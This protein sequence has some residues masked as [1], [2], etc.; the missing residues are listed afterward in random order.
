MEPIVIL[1]FGSQLSQLIARRIRE[2]GVYCELLPFDTP[3]ATI[4]RLSPRGFILSGGPN[5]V[6]DLESPDLPDYLLH[7]PL[8]KLGICYGMQLLARH[9]GGKVQQTGNQEYGL[10]KLHVI[11][12]SQLFK[13]LPSSFDVW[14]SHG[15]SITAVPSGFNVLAKSET[16]PIAAMEE[17]VTKVYGVLFHPEVSHTHHG[18]DILRNFVV[19][20]CGCNQNWLA[21]NIIE[22]SIVDIRSRVGND[23]VLCALSGGIDSAVT[24]I[25]LARAIGDRLTCVFVDHGMLRAN[26][27][28][29][30]MSL[31]GNFLDVNVVL[32]NVADRFLTRLQGVSDPET[33]RKIIGEEF[34][35]VFEDESRT[36]GPFRFLAQGTLYPDIIESA[37]GGK[38]DAARIK[39]HHNVGGLPAQMDF[40]LIEPLKRLFK[41][42]VR[43]I[44][45]QLGVPEHWLKRQ[46]YPGPGLANRIIGPVTKES[47]RLLQAADLIV[48]EEIERSGQWGNLWQYFAVLTP[49]Q[50]V[51]VMGDKRTYANVV[52]VRAVLSEDAMTAQW[53]PLPADLLG[54]IST[55]IVNE[56]AGINRVVYD[57]T[58]KP[59]ATIEWE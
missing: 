40:E 20:I 59:P 14:M 54:R 2:L 35:R 53:A 29:E 42:E 23:R 34:I 33:K 38:K 24:A 58:N 48:R 50:T 8:P 49:I 13:E 18:T 57:I 51:G 39:S 56:V 46:P 17:P 41:D 25:L 7:L 31:V 26:E 43:E 22:D 45:R 32:V 3:K 52:A 30:V 1:D 10:T 6:Y 36:R 16:M 11:H 12:N 19:E 28:D 27:S 37:G 5:S 44:A 47:I 21:S 4:E 55:R 9:L 15:D